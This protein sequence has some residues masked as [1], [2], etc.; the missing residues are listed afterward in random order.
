[1]VAEAVSAAVVTIVD[2]ADFA[3]LDAGSVDALDLDFDAVVVD[4]GFGA[5]GGTVG[6]AATGG[7]TG[8]VIAA[9]G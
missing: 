2:L 9:V 8:A 6:F 7:A 3:D 5:A 4:L 1:M